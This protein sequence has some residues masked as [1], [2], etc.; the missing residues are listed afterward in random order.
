LFGFKTAKIWLCE[1]GAYVGSH[2]KTGRPMGTLA[3][4]NLRALRVQA[5]ISFDSVWKQK[6]KTDNVS[7]R[8]ARS[9]G[10]AWLSNEL[11]IPLRKCHIGMFGET[12][13]IKTIKLCRDYLKQ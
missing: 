4:K 12:L 7:N 8:F 13:C 6:T 5:H 1:C 2:K 9:L 11:D 3:N 10:Y